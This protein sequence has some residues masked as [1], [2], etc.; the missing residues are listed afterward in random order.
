MLDSGEILIDRED[1][2]ELVRKI[3]KSEKRIKLLGSV[4]LLGYEDLSLA[5]YNL[6]KWNETLTPQDVQI[7]SQRFGN[8]NLKK[9]ETI[10]YLL[11]IMGNEHTSDRKEYV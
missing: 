7:R 4:E 6:R 11:E 2:H 10:V 5:R 1:I 9:K 8:G 3:L